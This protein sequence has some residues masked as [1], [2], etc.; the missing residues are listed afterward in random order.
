MVSV[1]PIENGDSPPGQAGA[2]PTDGEH[3]LELYELAQRLRLPTNE[4]SYLVSEG[5][6]R[7]YLFSFGRVRFMW[8]EVLEDI[9]AFKRTGSPEAEV[10]RE[11]AELRST[12]ADLPEVAAESDLARESTD[13]DF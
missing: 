11:M 2:M 13:K 10:Q 4:I 1:L 12:Y 8:R 7:Y 3:L 5:K 9:Q 6:L